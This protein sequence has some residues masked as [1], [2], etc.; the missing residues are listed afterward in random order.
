LIMTVSDE[1]ATLERQLLD[2]AQRANAA[3]VEHVLAA[4]FTEIGQSGRVYDKQAMLAQI[5]ETPGLGGSR[6][7]SDFSAREIGP[8][9][10][11]AMYRIVETRTTRSSIWRKTAGGWEMVF[12]QGTRSTD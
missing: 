1:I 12:N 8:D 5:R 11:L 10:V 7:L 2:P 6:T 4:D 9:L 3:F